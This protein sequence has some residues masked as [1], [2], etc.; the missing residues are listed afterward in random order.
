MAFGG[1][2]LRTTCSLN[3]FSYLGIPRSPFLPLKLE[4]Q[5]RER[6]IYPDR[7]GWNEYR[8]LDMDRIAAAMRG[9]TFVDLRNVYEADDMENAG[10]AYVC[11]GR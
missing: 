8:N 7:G 5:I 2:I 6:D 4:C 10:F 1:I 11:V 9:R 3:S